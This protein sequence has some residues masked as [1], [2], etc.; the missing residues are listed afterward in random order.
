M[1][2]PLRLIALLT[3]P[4]VHKEHSIWL[5]ESGTGILNAPLGILVRL[6]TPRA[7]V[8][9][10]KDDVW[11]C[12]RSSEWHSNIAFTYRR[13]MDYLN[14][15]ARLLLVPLTYTFQNTV[16]DW[17]CFNSSIPTTH[18]LQQ[19]GNANPDQSWT[20]WHPQLGDIAF[21]RKRKSLR[22]C[23]RIRTRWVVVYTFESSVPNPNERKLH[24]VPGRVTPQARLCIT[25][26]WNSPRQRITMR[27]VI[28]IILSCTCLLITMCRKP[29]P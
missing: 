10:F 17:S 12:N 7:S 9:D 16:R 4:L 1:L 19:K 8:E 15:L 27:C 28:G 18:S 22:V 26:E 29:G 20:E 3:S 25:V 24:L 11:N 2:V 5:F 21:Q 13:A 6:G 23:Q 14:Y